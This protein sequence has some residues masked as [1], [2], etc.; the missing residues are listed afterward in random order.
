[1]QLTGEIRSGLGRGSF[2]TSLDWVVEQ[3]EKAM[4]FKPFPGTLNVCLTGDDLER[5]DSFFQCDDF[6]LVPDN[7]E[8]C[9]AR[10][11]KVY[12][13]GLPAAVVFPSED[14]R[15]HGREILELIAGCHLKENLNLK[16]GD[17]VTISDGSSSEK[18]VQ[19]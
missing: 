15:A 17:Q 4:G 18:A 10:L 5:M 11:K 9:A 2:F 16:D 8:F 14:V 19:P 3:F 6:E 7:P 13:G 12:V 1:M